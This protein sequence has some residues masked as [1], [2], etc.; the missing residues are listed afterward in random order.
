MLLV[1]SFKCVEV[2]HPTLS[3]LWITGN[4]ARKQRIVWSGKFSDL[5]SD[6][7]RFHSCWHGDSYHRNFSGF[8]SVISILS[9]ISFLFLCS[10]TS[11]TVCPGVRVSRSR[12]YEVYS[13][14]LSDGVFSCHVD[15][16][17]CPSMYSCHFPLFAWI[18]QYLSRQMQRVLGNADGGTTWQPNGGG[19]Q[20]TVGNIYPHQIWDFKALKDGIWPAGFQ[21]CK[22]LL[23]SRQRNR[24]HTAFFQI[25]TTVYGGINLKNT[26]NL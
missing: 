21:E 23:S 11:K 7:D 4:N 19:R 26:D 20:V 1:T 24:T 25:S 5:Y 2:Y 16:M 15:Y 6:N 12:S 10:P 22:K 13:F 8:C 9:C 14:V 17:L 3:I 18:M